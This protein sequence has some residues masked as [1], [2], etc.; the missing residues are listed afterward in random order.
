MHLLGAEVG[1]PADAGQ[2]GVCDEDVDVARRRGELLG[3]PRLGE[4]R[5]EDPVAVARQRLRL[6][7]QRL[8]LAGAEQEGRAPGGEGVGDRPP[9]ASGGA[10]EESGA[11]GKF[12]PKAQATSGASRQE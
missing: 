10:G 1:Q 5:R 3:G 8:R 2:P 9:E 4:V 7:L 6:L 11:A 12:H